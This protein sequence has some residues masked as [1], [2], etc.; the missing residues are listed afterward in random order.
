MARRKNRHV[1]QPAWRPNFRNPETL[2]D[3]KVVRTDFLVN[4]FTVSLAAALLLMVLHR[5]M[6]ITD[7]TSQL[8]VAQQNIDSSIGNDRRVVQANSEFQRVQ[9]RVTELSTFLNVPVGPDDL[10]HAIAS[11]QPPEVI[12]ESLSFSPNV[13]RQGR[14][15]IV[16]YRIV[17]NGR[18]TDGGAPDRQ[19]TDII[20]Q[21]RNAFSSLKVLAPYF[22]NSELTGFS[23]NEQTGSFN[24]AITVTLSAEP[25]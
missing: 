21:Y 5:E 8:Q 17:L 10:L 22:E 4:V 7:Y 11:L 20:T 16:R 3:I 14:R 1:T 15:E 18:V 6:R 2:P 13:T 12:L 25:K 19:A 9:R 24:F 23:R